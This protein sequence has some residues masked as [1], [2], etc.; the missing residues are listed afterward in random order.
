MGRKFRD[1]TPNLYSKS[2]DTSGSEITYY[3]N[4][5]VKTTKDEEGNLKQYTYD[6]YGN[7][8]NETAPNGS[9]YIYDYDNM[10][11]VVKK[12]FKDN[13]SASQVVLEEYSYEIN[14]SNS[15]NNNALRVNKK[16]YI[17]ST[18]FTTSS[19]V[20]NYNKQIVQAINEDQTTTKT[21]YM[22]N[23]MK[24][25]ETDENNVNHY[26][27]YDGLNRLVSEYK[28]VDNSTGEVLYSYSKYDYDNNGNKIKESVGRDLVK[29]NAVTTNLAIKESSY[30]KNGKLKAQWD[31]EARKSEYEYD[32]NGNVTKQTVYTDK[33][34]GKKII[35]Y[36]NNYLNKPYKKSDQV[37]AGDIF[38]NAIDSTTV[39]SLDTT[40][41]YDLNGNLI[42][43]T[44]P[45]GH[46]ISYVYD[47][48]DRQISTTEK[49]LDETG[50]EVVSTT[51]KAYE[52]N[53]QTKETV[54]AKGNK[55]QYQYDAMGVQVAE[56]NAKGDKTTYQHDLLGRITTKIAAKDVM[57]VPNIALDEISKYYGSKTGD[58]NWNVKYDLNKD[59]LVDIFDIVMVSKKTPI[60]AAYPTQTKLIYN[61]RGLV[62]AEQKVV[63]PN[64]D[65]TAD[66]T[67]TKAYKYDNKGNKIKELDA[68]GYNAGTGTSVEEK[69]NSGYGKEYQYNLSGKLVTE[70]T[71]ANKDKGLT[72]THKYQYDGLLRM[73]KDTDAN[74]NAITYDYNNAGKVTSKKLVSASGT[75]ELAR[76]EYDLLDNVTLAVD[77]N[78]NKTTT[79]Y[80]S[81]NKPK[82]TILPGDSSILGDSIVYQYD[83]L[84]NQ[85]FSQNSKGIISKN[86]RDPQGKVLITTN[87]DSAGTNSIN[88]EVKYDKNGNKRFV[89]DGNGNVTTYDYDELN[90][91][92]STSIDVKNVNGVVVTHKTSYEYDANNNVVKETDYLGNVSVSGYDAFDRLIAKYDGSGKLVEKLDYNKNGTQSKSTDALGNVT[93]FEY[94]KDN[95]L[96]SKTD[97]E[98]NKSSQTYDKVGNVDTR[99]DAKGNKTVY[100]Y[101][102][103]NRLKS[104]LNAKSE[105][106][107]YTYDNNGNML[108][109]TDAKGNKTIYE[110]NVGN[111]VSKII[112]PKGKTISGTTITYD[113]TKV[114]EFTYYENGNVKT[115]KDQNGV[116]TQYSY[117][118]FGRETSEINPTATISFEY[119][120]NGNQTKMTDSTGVT[121]REYDALNRVITKTVPNIGKSTYLYDVKDGVDLG[122]YA[123]VSNDPKAN[124]VKKV[125]DKS[126]RL[127]KVI[128]GT[129]TTAYEYYDNGA[130]K[131]TVYPDGSREDYQ[132]NKNNTL[133]TL[134][135]KNSNSTVI[136]S[137]SYTY[138]AAGNI[139]SKTDKKGQ[140]NYEY[141]ALNRVTS[142]KEPGGKNTSYTYDLSG[143]RQTETVVQNN[144]TNITTYSYD[145]QN[146]LIQTTKMQDT[147]VLGYKK[148]FYDNNGNVTKEVAGLANFVVPQAVSTRMSDIYNSP[149][150]TYDI[151]NSEIKDK[152]VANTVTTL[153]SSSIASDNTQ[154]NEKIVQ[155]SYDNFNQLTEAKNDA[156]TIL[157]NTYNGEGLR[158]SKEQGAQK[159]NLLY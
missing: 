72:F 16:A 35:T 50:T 135:N 9:I 63:Y 80:N 119:D 8:K 156:G 27:N 84:G 111:K 78:G 96:I 69:I 55:T 57:I 52:W 94:D 126:D 51:T 33:N 153:I 83:K 128:D 61:S 38:G 86:Q 14:Y 26:Y 30:Y 21:E 127:V 23:G 81:L 129:S 76:Y 110:Y 149:E 85:V 117:D 106:T 60:Q 2:G 131:S 91:I 13:A 138:D 133:K 88:Q 42:K 93:S 115:H 112:A 114:Q 123:E 102:E 82:Q 97:A 144:V 130:K 11:R 18:N 41:N 47:N 157:K 49:T 99:T 67:V 147:T 43:Q 109:Q 15:N 107:T 137:F 92:K 53:G 45:D 6:V 159:T 74:N 24:A 46:E 36:A 148:Y 103:L 29:N 5:R 40:Y 20:Y 151:V 64:N 58:A 68:L 146:R 48:L 32:G 31:N 155:Y 150:K 17:D 140:T 77:G 136:E 142:V 70:N 54:D 122:F 132:Y 28:P 73:V 25:Y 113:A 158:V 139:S 87:T 59:G 120:K 37:V 7:V 116:V 125:Y 95:R 22:K 124:S 143:N 154:F 152:V 12:S 100:S 3:P 90:R 1:I 105:S 10:N 89:K 145:E 141:D 101:D 19:L 39:L 104:V 44:S 34:G 98:N 134:V 71:A 62:I 118:I 121:L 108:E 56:I 75:K 79:T 4:G 65:A 66:I